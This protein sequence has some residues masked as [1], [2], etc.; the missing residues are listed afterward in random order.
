MRSSRTYKE[1]DKSPEKSVYEEYFSKLEGSF[2][3]SI[4]IIVNDPIMECFKENKESQM[5]M[6]ERIKEVVTQSLQEAQDDYNKEALQR[7]D[8]MRD[9]TSSLREEIKQVSISNKNLKEKLKKKSQGRN[10]NQGSLEVKSLQIENEKLENNMQEIRKEL[11]DAQIKVRDSENLLN[12]KEDVVK[13]LEDTIMQLES[14]NN[15]ARAEMQ[16]LS[17]KLKETMDQETKYRNLYLDLKS[18]QGGQMSSR[19]NDKCV[20]CERLYSQLKKMKREKNQLEKMN[21]ELERVKQH[22]LKSTQNRNDELE[23][24]LNDKDKMFF[25]KDQKIEDLEFTVKQ[26]EQTVATFKRELTES[27]KRVRE[28]RKYRHSVEISMIELK[29][30]FSELTLEAK[31]VRDENQKS[32]QEVKKIF[33]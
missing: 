21:S 6:F 2:R 11:K 19:T 10:S 3:E 23:K 9:F 13:K 33:I 25:Q 12:W 17:S 20:N 7:L 32:R 30:S 16:N 27:T 22:D 4:Q 14:E 31:S 8:D 29:D 28:E 18:N 5:F 26:L 1:Q 15:S 24:E